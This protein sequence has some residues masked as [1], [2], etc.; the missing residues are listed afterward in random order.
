M[1]AI[2]TWKELILWIAAIGS[3]A[4]AIFGFLSWRVSR[5]TSINEWIQGFSSLVEAEVRGLTRRVVQTEV[6]REKYTVKFGVGLSFL[7]NLIKLYKF[8]RLLGGRLR[9]ILEIDVVVE[10]EPGELLERSK[11]FAEQ[12]KRSLELEF[13]VGVLQR[14]ALNILQV[15]LFSELKDSP[16]E[17]YELYAKRF[18]EATEKAILSTIRS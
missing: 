7:R 14:K 2:V 9:G 3:L 17:S 18:Y 11:G 16:A 4:A 8:F 15:K 10:V 13:N 1:F 12:L 5:M 6:Q